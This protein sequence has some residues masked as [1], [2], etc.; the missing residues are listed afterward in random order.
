MTERSAGGPVVCIKGI[1]QKNRLA[2][3]ERRVKKWHDV[4]KRGIT[5][6]YSLELNIEYQLILFHFGWFL[7]G[8]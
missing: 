5:R 8:F 4:P 7:V 3:Q 6:A 2:A 1:H